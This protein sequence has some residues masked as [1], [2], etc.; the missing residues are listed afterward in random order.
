[1]SV[2]LEPGEPPVPEAVSPEGDRLVVTSAPHRSTTVRRARPC[3]PSAAASDSPA[4]DSTFA[5][6]G[7]ATNPLRLRP[8]SEFLVLE[9]TVLRP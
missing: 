6:M 9:W 1:M 4:P 3:T 8:P 5:F 2:R 7:R